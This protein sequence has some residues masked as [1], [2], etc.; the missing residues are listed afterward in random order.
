VQRLIETLPNSDKESVGKHCEKLTHFDPA[1]C[2]PNE[3]IFSVLSY[4]SPNDLLACGSV[5]RGWREKAMDEKLWRCCFAQEGWVV[6]R[7]KLDDFEAKAIELK[8]RRRSVSK[9]RRP[10]ELE[11]RGSRKRKPGEAFSDAE[12]SGGVPF[13]VTGASDISVHPNMS[14]SN[15]EGM[16]GMERSSIPPADSSTDAD[17]SPRS[18]ASRVA[19]RLSVPP[20]SEYH[21]PPYIDVAPSIWRP[22][23]ADTPKLSWQYLYKQRARLEKNWES[24]KSHTMFSLP[25]PQYANEGHRECVYTIQHTSK[26]LVSGSRDK[27]IRKWDLETYRL[28]GNPLEGH[29]ASVLCL[30]FDERPEH[31]I[32]VSGGSDSAVIIWRFSTGELIKRLARAHNESVLNLRFDD[33]YIVTCSKDKSIKI[34]NRR[35][36]A[37]DDPIIPVR[38]IEQWA[39]APGRLSDI[40]ITVPEYTML[41][42]LEGHQAA[43][44]AVMIQDNVIIS[45]S[46]DR[47]IKSWNIKETRLDKTYIGHTK[48]IACVQYDGRRIVSGSSDNTVRIFDAETQAEVACLTGHGNLVRTVQARFG[49]LDLVTDEELENEAKKID[50]NFFDAV[51]KGMVLASTARGSLR[52]AGS[53]RPQDMLAF[54]TKIPPGGGGS[55]WAKIVSGSYDESVIIWKRGRDGK[56]AK[57]QI[58]GQE[59]LL[60]R[61]F[62]RPPR[63]RTMPPIP[64]PIIHGVQAHPLPNITGPGGQAVHHAAAP[65][66]QLNQTI[67]ATGGAANQLLPN[68]QMM[69]IT[70]ISTNLNAQIQNQQNG[71]ANAGQMAVPAAP[72]HNTHPQPG[73]GAN[74]APAAA[75]A[76]APQPGPTQPQP[77][78][79]APQQLPH[80]GAPNHHHHGHPV[81]RHHTS[82]SHR[83]FKLQFDARRIICCSQNRVI[84]GWDFANGDKELERIGDWSVETA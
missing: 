55:K 47:T 22:G 83:V 63:P 34:W 60:R 31:D 57:R 84:V 49:D 74:L 77:P 53:S 35:A 52:N 71:N 33:R 36:I 81:I 27:T 23:P 39:K 58:L 17:N 73:G 2:L 24:E 46:G 43:V 66:N 56:W 26:Y 7:S 72:H 41:A 21:Q 5:S 14:G 3:L 62:P 80:A 6:D 16:D 25:L 30:Q 28:I 37:K 69:N 78:P 44:N 29:T 45:A 38:T 67:Q 68:H 51:D 20:P 70:T 59:N 11:R 54:G 4:L 61:S 65:A 40:D 48:G 10:T 42:K 19:N 13:S 82:D 64:N 75:H 15:R 32:I 8:A 50:S 76:A 1:V 18:S 12:N 9:V 79:P